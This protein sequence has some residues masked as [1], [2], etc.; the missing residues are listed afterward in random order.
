MIKLKQLYGSLTLSELKQEI[1]SIKEIQKNKIKY[2]SVLMSVYKKDS[3]NDL[4]K[5]FASIFRNSILPSQIVIVEDGPLTSEL[6]LV[7][8]SIKECW[9][10]RIDI[11][12][13]K[14]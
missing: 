6:Y 2:F 14:Q 12:T 10:N 9:P 13:L 4:V 1:E 8:R 7:I 5:T 11:I 3:A